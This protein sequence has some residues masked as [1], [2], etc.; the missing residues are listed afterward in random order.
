V[1]KPKTAIYKKIHYCFVNT[2]YAEK[3]E[4]HSRLN[5]R[6][7]MFTDICRIVNLSAEGG[8]WNASGGPDKDRARSAGGIYSWFNF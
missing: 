7:L 4:I 6:A 3:S 8:F 5:I 2:F 1:G